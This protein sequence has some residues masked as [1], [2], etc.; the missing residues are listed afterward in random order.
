MKKPLVRSL[1]LTVI[2]AL[3]AQ[4]DSLIVTDALE[5]VV[6]F[7]QAPA[8]VAVAGKASFMLADAV[9]LFP[10][11]RSR[12]VAR[13]TGMQARSD[14]G[15]FLALVAGDA[16]K[17][18]LLSGNAGIEAIAVVRPDAVLLKSSSVRLGGEL[19][20]LG[21]PAVYLDFET[22]DQYGRDL[23][24]VGRVLGAMDRARA[25]AAYYDDIT[26]RVRVGTASLAE[27]DRP[28]TLLLQY[29]ERSGAVAFSVPPAD[30]MQTRLV[31]LAG[32]IPVWKNEAVGGGWTVVTLE[33]VA[34]WDPDC[35][36]VVNY[37]DSAA[38]AVESLRADALWQHLRAV[39][40]GRLHAVPSDFYSW[41]QPDTRWGLGLLWLATRLHPDRFRDVD[42]ESEL[43]RFYVLYGLDEEAVRTTVRPLIHEP[44]AASKCGE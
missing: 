36:L 1:A 19:E 42:L 43:L 22:P 33:Q 44:L 23:A 12:V 31:E 6:R 15:D 11:A 21:L 10:E 41:D 26:E 30:W 20:R 39:R 32:G 18:T 28:R 17:T 29:S 9:Y 16:G 13:A 34:A 5:R 37:S 14:A 7:A 27:A 35:V 2:L 24:T 38:R 4:A 8:R 3:P 40:A 25:V